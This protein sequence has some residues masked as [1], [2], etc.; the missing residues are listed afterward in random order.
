MKIEMNVNKAVDIYKNNT[1]IDL[2]KSRVSKKDTI[3]ISSKGK[4]LSEYVK[5]AKDTE[6]KNDKVDRIKKL[7]A[8]KNYKVDSYKLADSMI[9]Y[10]KESDR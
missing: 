5:I 3:E 6:L 8:E 10:I 2:N 4:E 7:V 9:Q 1:K